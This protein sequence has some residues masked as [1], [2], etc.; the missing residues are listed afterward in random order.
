M[1]PTVDGWAPTQ[2]ALRAAFRGRS[3][4]E[5]HLHALRKLGEHLATFKRQRKQAGQPVSDTEEV[6]IRTAF[7]RVL[8]APTAQAYH[9]ALDELPAVFDMEPLLSRKQSLST[10]QAV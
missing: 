5:C 8:Q 4:E 9:Q 1:G 3:L 10:K 2:P 7:L 6:A